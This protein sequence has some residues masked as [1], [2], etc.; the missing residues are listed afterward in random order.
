MVIKHRHAHRE[1]CLVYR[2]RL[3]ICSWQLGPCGLSYG[4]AKVIKP[5]TPWWTHEELGSY[6]MLLYLWSLVALCLCST[7]HPV[8]GG[9]QHR[10]TESLRLE[11]TSKTIKSN[12]PP[13]TT[14]PTRPCPK[15]S[16]LHI[17]W[18]P[19]GMGTPPLPW[20]ACSNAWPLFH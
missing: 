20:A 10:I 14:M 11:N 19:P 12:H 2:A 13:N 1:I 9:L 8:L 15:V 6:V 5:P 18:T 17:F 7:M 16:Y 3:T 4:A